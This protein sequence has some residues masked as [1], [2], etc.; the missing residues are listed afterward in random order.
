MVWIDSACDGV[1]WKDPLVLVILSL[2][3]K[4]WDKSPKNDD[5]CKL[6]FLYFEELIET[7]CVI[8]EP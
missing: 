6:Q 1:S 7:K 2:V 5:I 8:H 4:K 3:V